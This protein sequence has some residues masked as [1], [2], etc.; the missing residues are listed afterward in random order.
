VKP[1]AT[2]Y[3]K[4]TCPNGVQGPATFTPCPAAASAPDVLAER[5]LYALAVAGLCHGYTADNYAA[6]LRDVPADQHYAVNYLF[7]GLGEPLMSGSD[8]AAAEEAEFARVERELP[9]APSVPGGTRYAAAPATNLSPDAAPRD[10][11]RSTQAAPAAGAGEEVG[12]CGIPL[13]RA[14]AASQDAVVGLGNCDWLD[15]TTR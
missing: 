2:C 6:F 10:Q 1:L 11:T 12:A 5:I 4:G 13:S 15:R 7:Y 3:E 14:N 9:G 8:A